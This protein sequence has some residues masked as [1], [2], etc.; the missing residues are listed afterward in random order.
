[1]CIGNRDG[2]DDAI[3]PYVA[4]KLNEIKLDDVMVL[5]CGMIP[6]NYTAVV[7]QH[8]P[9]NLVIIDAVEMDLAPGE[10]RIIPEKNIGTM[11]IS[12]HGIPLSVLMKYLREYVANIFFIGIQA[13]SMSG[14][15]TA[16]VK[17][18]GNRLVEVIINK[19]F[20][21]IEMLQ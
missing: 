11:H 3:G 6:E 2:G 19:H 20:N 15:M 13:Q 4:D 8:K 5:D 21:Q 7:K 17:K 18:G 16:A 9:K 12:T 14:K 1:M 10:I